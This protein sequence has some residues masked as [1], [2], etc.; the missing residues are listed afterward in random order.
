MAGRAEFASPGGLVSA[1]FVMAADSS[2]DPVWVKS[3]GGN[4]ARVFDSQIEIKNC[5]DGYI[6][7]GTTRTLQGNVELE[8]FLLRIDNSGNPLYPM[9][10]YSQ[11]PSPPSHPLLGLAFKD[12]EQLPGGGFIVTGHAEVPITPGQRWTQTILME[13]DLALTPEWVKRYPSNSNATYVNPTS[14]QSVAIMPPENPGFAVLGE[15]HV[16]SKQVLTELF[17]VGPGGDWIAGDDWYRKINNVKPGGTVWGGNGGMNYAANGSLRHMPNTGG[18]VFCGIYAPIPGGPFGNNT[19]KER[20]AL[21]KYALDGDPLWARWF[22]DWG[23]GQATSFSRAGPQ[24]EVVFVASSRTIKGDIDYQVALTNSDFLSGCHEESFIVDDDNREIIPQPVDLTVA[25]EIDGVT[26][27]T[28]DRTAIAFDMNTHFERL[29]SGIPCFSVVGWEVF[30]DCGP[31]PDDDDGVVIDWTSISGPLDFTEIRR[32]GE[33]IAVVDGTTYSDLPGPGFHR[34][35]LTF[36]SNIPTCNPMQASCLVE[37]PDGL[38]LAEV[39]DL[40]VSAASV[41]PDSAS[42]CLVEILEGLGRQTRQVGNLELLTTELGSSDPGN[43]PV[44]W[45]Q[46]GEYP[47]QQQLSNDDGIRLVDF[48]LAGGSLYMEGADVGFDLP[49]GLSQ[50]V[51]MITTD[52]GTYGDYIPGLDGLDSGHGLDASQLSAG[53]S[54]SGLY[55]DHLE[56]VGPGSGIIF[57]NSGDPDHV[58]AVYHDAS[59]AGTGTHRV[60]T[61]ATILAGYMGNGAALIETLTGTLGSIQESLFRRADFNDDGGV[62]I[63]DAINLLGY[64]FDGGATTGCFDAGDVNDDGFLNIADAINLLG[65][66]F[67]GCPPAPEP[68]SS[69]CGEDPT[70][71]SLNCAVQNSCP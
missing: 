15:L 35:D 9:T 34:Y 2:G 40:I 42:E 66:L 56:P 16:E 57:I 52:P 19:L 6:L 24:G 60:V 27:S 69:D 10:F 43:T 37:I 20:S 53:Y 65:I 63:A 14:G 51:G 49:G 50:M 12:V 8:G 22:G 44:V 31:D 64:L 3:Y 54:H 48:L 4:L 47:D 11:P 59:A 71:D 62:N 55:V 18:L 46:L 70:P 21:V 38:P 25:T 67:S 32:E 7:C 23:K 36:F 13:T 30:P 41:T 26:A 33:L 45:L 39:N 28:V 68:G 5:D 29:C 61:S 58:T 1:I 17:R